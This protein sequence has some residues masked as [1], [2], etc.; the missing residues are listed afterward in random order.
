MNQA[1]DP[2]EAPSRVAETKDR[3]LDSAEKLFAEHGF[4]ATSLRHITTE[5]GVNLAA[6]N[7]HFHSK[8]ALFLAVLMRKLEPINR[9]RLELLTEVEAE[10]GDDPLSLEAVLGAFLLPVLEAKATRVQLCNFPKL[11]GRMYTEPGDWSAR[12]YPEAFAPL[13]ARFNP[14][15]RRAL[16]GAEPAEIGW[17]MHFS[18]GAMA[19]FLAGGPLLKAVSEGLADSSDTLAAFPKMV[20]YMSGGLRALTGVKEVAR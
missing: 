5:A 11:M 17:G 15:F 14:A 18:I 19:H 3:I 10:A 20:A 12:I 9:R 8:D 1:F 16:P 13:I 4:A 7:Y 6:V 2:D